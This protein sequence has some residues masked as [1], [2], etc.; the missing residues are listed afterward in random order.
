MGGANQATR[1]GKTS[2]P[3]LPCPPSQLRCPL[4][5]VGDWAFSTFPSS[6]SRHQP[7]ASS[8][9]GHAPHICSRPS[10]LLPPSVLHRRRPFASS[11]LLPL[12]PLVSL[13]LHPSR[14]VLHLPVTLHAVSSSLALTSP[15]PPPTSSSSLCPDLVSYHCLCVLL[16]SSSSPP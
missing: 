3:R 7:N 5:D 9:S 10:S 8:T 13:G 16:P 15:P 1:V 12:F 2:L 14:R 4:I 6:V 11:S